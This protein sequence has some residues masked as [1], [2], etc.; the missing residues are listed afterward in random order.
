MMP[1]RYVAGVRTILRLGATSVKLPT[2]SRTDFRWSFWWA[3]RG[4]VFDRLGVQ[5]REAVGVYRA[6]G[7]LAPV[8]GLLRWG[9][10]SAI[11]RCVGSVIVSTV[12]GVPRRWLWPH[13]R[14]KVSKRVCPPC[15]HP[16][17][18]PS[19]SGVLRIVGVGATLNHARPRF[20]LAGVAHPV[21]CLKR[22]DVSHNL[23]ALLF[24]IA[25]TTHSRGKWT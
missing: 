21:G 9:C 12:D 5:V 18:A 6:W 22:H 2:A 10:P 4:E 13:V 24:S 20:V 23:S 1:M 3:H 25:H 11:L 14:E 8:V 17:P 7:G 15:G 16:N 19:V